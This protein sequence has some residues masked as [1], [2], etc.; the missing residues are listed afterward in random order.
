[1]SLYKTPNAESF[2]RFHKWMMDSVF[3]PT[4][5]IRFQQH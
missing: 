1:M 2:E 5:C 3:A 4:W